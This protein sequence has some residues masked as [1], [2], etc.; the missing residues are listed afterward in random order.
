[1]GQKV[2]SPSPSFIGGFIY[3]FI[4]HKKYFSQT[5]FMPIEIR[6]TDALIHELVWGKERDEAVEAASGVIEK[7]QVS[8][9]NGNWFQLYDSVNGFNVAQIARNAPN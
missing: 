7:T 3:L 8:M 5:L 9:S 2:Q 1:M 6:Y 4:S